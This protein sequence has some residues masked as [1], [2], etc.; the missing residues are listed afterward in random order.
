MLLTVI[1]RMLAIDFMLI[2]LS[3][4][5]FEQLPYT[6]KP[7][8]ALHHE[9]KYIGYPMAYTNNHF[10]G[11]QIDSLKQLL[12]ITPSACYHTSGD[13]LQDNLSSMLNS[14]N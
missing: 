8:N 3:L 9:L 2:L 11:T 13:I 6:I 14:V 4:S 7:L 10:S 1:Q 5:F 12:Q